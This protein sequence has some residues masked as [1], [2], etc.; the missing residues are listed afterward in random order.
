[1]DTLTQAFII[2]AAIDLTFVGTTTLFV[3]LLVTKIL[4]NKEILEE[5]KKIV[6]ILGRKK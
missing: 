4:F 3:V 2:F 6:E 5:I 1:M